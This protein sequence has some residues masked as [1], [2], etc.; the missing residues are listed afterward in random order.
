MSNFIPWD[1]NHSRPIM[2]QLQSC[3]HEDFCPFC[4][5]SCLSISYFLEFV[6]MLDTSIFFFKCIAN[7]VTHIVA[8]LFNHFT[9]YFD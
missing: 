5:L 1:L 3:S 7:I 4:L 8:C 9:I 6:Y 2:K